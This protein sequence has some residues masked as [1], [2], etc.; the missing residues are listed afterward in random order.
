MSPSLPLQHTI[1]AVRTLALSDLIV[2][3]DLQHTGFVWALKIT[4]FHFINISYCLFALEDIYDF[5]PPFFFHDNRC[6]RVCVK[7]SVPPLSIHSIN[8]YRLLSPLSQSFL[9]VHSGSLLLSFP[10]QFFFSTTWKL[11]SRHLS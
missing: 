5:S 1:E 11:Q 8:L 4:L 6:C 9:E 7:V 3:L 10:A 2:H